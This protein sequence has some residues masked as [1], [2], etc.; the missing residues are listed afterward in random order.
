MICNKGFFS[1]S[2]SMKQIANRHTTRFRSMAGLAAIF[3][4]SMSIIVLSGYIAHIRVLQSFTM[5]VAM[6]PVT[7]ILFF[8]G[9]AT[10]LILWQ[11]NPSRIVIRI[12]IFAAF[13]IASLGAIKVVGVLTNQPVYFDQA[14]FSNQLIQEGLQTGKENEIAPNS[15]L[16]FFF[17]GL[18]VYFL[19]LKR[20]IYI[21]QGLTLATFFIALIVLLGYLYDAERFTGI[22]GDMPMAL[23]AT[24]TFAVLSLGII[25]VRANT[26]FIKIIVDYGAGGTMIRKLVPVAVIVPA[27]LGYIHVLAEEKQW[28]SYDLV[29]ALL[30][31]A[32][33]I[34]IIGVI[35]LHSAKIHRLDAD[36]Q[37]ALEHFENLNAKNV[38]ILDSIGEGL[39]ATDAS[40]RI[41]L[42]ND[43]AGKLL[44]ETP[45]RLL[46]PKQR[47]SAMILYNHE[48]GEVPNNLRPCWKAL[49]TGKKVVSDIV[50]NDRY[51]VKRKD[52]TAIPIAITATPVKLHQ[53][54][55][56]V[57]IIFR[58]LT[59]ELALEQTKTEFISLATHQLQTPP[60]AISWNTEL[61]LQGDAGKLSPQQRSLVNDIHDTSK[62]MTEIV[63]ALLNAA[64]LELGTYMVEPKPVDVVELCHNEAKTFTSAL[65]T[66]NLHIVEHYESKI[67]TITADPTL[68]RV[69]LQNLISNA[70][71][72]TQKEGTITLTIKKA[73]KPAGVTISVTDTGV[74]IP[75]NQQ[76]LIFSKMFRADNVRENSQGTG[77]GL[78]LVKSIVD[79]SHGKIWFESKENKGTTFHVFLPQ[80]G[81]HAKQGTSR[82]TT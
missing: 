32:N 79:L 33:I 10:L 31:M 60:T 43:S 1:I 40:F 3:A 6:N 23:N 48:G 47:E 16:C 8:L 49:H 54:T 19:L 2:E 20:N 37:T 30:V 53:K 26:G 9:G 22:S 72:Y 68:T 64:R 46:E 65:E 69:I 4:M 13:F 36:R 59:S 24:I 34:L 70:V 73:E 76:T 38:A 56:G 62:G 28:L 41:L 42:A 14:L 52:G 74:G 21:A 35:V 12:G 63:H 17:L 78:Y 45:S 66:N 71:K 25:L 39:I 11:T 77:L 67:P 82:I 75:K 5:P 57:V 58:D 27:L 55:I 81:I 80:I 44:G 7:A 29:T 15:A 61:L 18:A 51:F 50:T